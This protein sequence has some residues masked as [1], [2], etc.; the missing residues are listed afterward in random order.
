[1][2]SAGGDDARGTGGTMS[3][4]PVVGHNGAETLIDFQTAGVNNYAFGDSLP[5]SMGKTVASS[6]H[7]HQFYAT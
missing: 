2:L 3:N 5:A 6:A 4:P 7:E 1:M